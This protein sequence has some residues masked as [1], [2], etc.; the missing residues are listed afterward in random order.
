MARQPKAC[1]GRNIVILC[2]RTGNEIGAMAADAHG[3]TP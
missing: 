1:A 2:D 3:D